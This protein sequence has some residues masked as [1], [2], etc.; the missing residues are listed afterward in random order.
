MN[1]SVKTLVGGIRRMAVA[2]IR[3]GMARVGLDMM[4]C[5]TEGL[6]EA[7]RSRRGTIE[8]MVF[9]GNQ[10]KRTNGSSRLSTTEVSQWKTANI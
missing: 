6:G 2:A 7:E 9:S 1:L 5:R 10:R 3:V 8:G 4:T